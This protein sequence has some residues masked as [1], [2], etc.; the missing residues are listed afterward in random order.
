MK[1]DLP[2]NHGLP[3]CI[4]REQ[5]ML[6]RENG[7]Y[8]LTDVQWDALNAGIARGKSALVLAPTSTGKTHIAIW[9]MAAWLA[10][11]P[12]HRS[13]YLVTHRSLANQKFDEFRRIFPGSVFGRG[14]ADAIV[15]ATGDH[16]IDGNGASVNDPLGAALLV[17][18]YEKYLGLLCSIGIPTDLQN[19]CVVADEIQIIG[20]NAR[21]LNVEIL[22]TMVI[23]AKPAQFVGLSAVLDDDGKTLAEWMNIEHIR[24]LNREKHLRFECRTHSRRLVFD[25]S[26]PENGIQE[27]PMSPKLASDVN[28]LIRERMAL[29]EGRPIVVFCMSKKQVYEGS[30]NYCA[31]QGYSLDNAPLLPGLSSDTYEGKLLSAMM[32]HRVAIHCADL[33]EEDRLIVEKYIKEQKIDLV[34]AT[35]TLAA[36]V[37]FPLATVIFSAWTRWN[38]KRHRHELISVA[39]FHSMAGRCGR[40]GT[41]HSNGQVFLF[42]GDSS[43]DRRAVKGFL[44]PDRADALVSQVSPDCFVSTLLQLVASDIVHSKREALDFLGKTY[45]GCQAQVGNISGLAHWGELLDKAAEE[46]RDGGFLR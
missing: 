17:A 29:K 1:F 45:G 11:G 26:K 36:G 21:G 37:N 6:F 4:L 8:S 25:T 20:D 3:D 38:G 28:S 24:S 42:A 39:E 13:V 46:L 15:L 30:R 41:P 14:E 35:S 18:T 44:D 31:E 16:Q 22:L 40:M 5:R 43:N 9:A 27:K 19:T 32:P 33:V 7:K 34:F 23:H 2:P 12:G 10:R